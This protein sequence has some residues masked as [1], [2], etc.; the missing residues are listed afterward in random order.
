VNVQFSHCSLRHVYGFY[1]VFVT[2][3]YRASGGC[4]ISGSEFVSYPTVHT[5]VQFRVLTKRDTAGVLH[6]SL[7]FSTWMIF[8]YRLAVINKNVRYTPH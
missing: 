3:V 7:V 1:L 4:V 5:S 6:Q 2:N 8:V